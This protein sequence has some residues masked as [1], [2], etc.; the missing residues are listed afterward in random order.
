MG[1]LKSAWTANILAGKHLSPFEWSENGGYVI[2]K[3]CE[4]IR[5]KHYL[6]D[7]CRK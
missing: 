1:I 5:V 3:S 6:E 2:A 7:I 4:Y